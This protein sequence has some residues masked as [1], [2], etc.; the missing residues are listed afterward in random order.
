MSEVLSTRLEDQD[1][2]F[3]ANSVLFRLAVAIGL[4]DKDNPE[5]VVVDP[6][7]LLEEVEFRLSLVEPVIGT[8]EVDDD[9]W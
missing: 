9:T 7:E 4:V 3:W 8:E 2:E 1:P 6:D 5:D